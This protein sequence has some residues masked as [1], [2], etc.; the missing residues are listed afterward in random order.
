MSSVQNPQDPLLPSRRERL[1]AWAMAVVLLVLVALGMALGRVSVGFAA[2]LAIGI[3]GWP[4]LWLR[5][6]ARIARRSAPL[7]S[8]GAPPPSEAPALGASVIDG[9]PDPLLIL[10]GKREVAL[11]NR[12]AR[13]LLGR[14][15]T[16]R[17]ITFALRQPH[18]LAQ[19]DKALASAAPGETEVTLLAPVSRVFHV[20]VAPLHGTPA[21]AEQPAVALSLHEITE[22]RQAEN[23]RADFVANASHE[24]K[25]PLANLVGFIETL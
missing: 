7:P 4:L 23:M 22:I 2:L 6:G 25:T 12:A 11:A 21:A 3:A 9:L 8:T 19:V 10:N 20:L 17:D 15:L 13:Q 16:G 24:L 18:V 1:A 5:H 14:T